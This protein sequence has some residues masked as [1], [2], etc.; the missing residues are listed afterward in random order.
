LLYP[1]MSLAFA[2][3]SVSGPKSISSLEQ[4]HV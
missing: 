3:P 1:W 2:S 4:D